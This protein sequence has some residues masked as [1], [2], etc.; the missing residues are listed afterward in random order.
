MLQ[1]PSWLTKAKHLELLSMA[2]FVAC[3]TTASSLHQAAALALCKAC[4][5]PHSFLLGAL[6]AVVVG[7]IRMFLHKLL[8]LES[9]PCQQVVF[10]H[11]NQLPGPPVKGIIPAAVDFLADTTR[12][13]LS[14]VSTSRPDCI[15]L[16]SHA[17]A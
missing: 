12:T 2:Q 17:P 5:K 7:L 8:W 15:M 14:M 6:L 3:H 4:G 16:C 11:P 1:I 13:V 10:I 9:V